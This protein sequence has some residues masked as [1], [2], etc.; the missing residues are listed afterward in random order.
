MLKFK[1]KSVAKMLMDS[2]LPRMS[3]YLELSATH[4]TCFEGTIKLKWGFSSYRMG[5][6]FLAR[7]V[8][9]HF[10]WSQ[11]VHLQCASSPKGS[12]FD[13]TSKKLQAIE[14]FRK[15][16]EGLTKPHSLAS[17]KNWL[18]SNNSMKTWKVCKSKTD[19]CRFILWHFYSYG[20]NMIFRKIS[21]SGD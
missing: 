8:L 16:K 20:C 6:C 15:I 13:Q 14:S 4:V 7:M 21:K 11:L 2:D 9:R 10:D 3:T 17:Q 1:K 5:C 18:L 12:V 19:V